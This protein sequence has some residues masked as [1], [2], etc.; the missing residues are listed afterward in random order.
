MSVQH[1]VEFLAAE[2]GH[3]LTRVTRDNGRSVVVTTDGA[4]EWVADLC[5]AAHARG[6]ELLFPDDWRY[7]FAQ[8]ALSALA[9]GDEG[10]PDLDAVYPYTADRLRW[11]ASRADR[12]GYYDDAV[13]EFGDY[14]GGVM[15]LVALGMARELDEVFDA[16]RA[17]LA[18]RVEQLN[19][20]AADESDD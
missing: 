3:W 2:A 7:E 17:F 4:P 15:G 5:R 12:Y 9:D 13:E 16:V 10:A 20:E 8:D 18:D 1:T 14:S 11:L 6:G 19:A